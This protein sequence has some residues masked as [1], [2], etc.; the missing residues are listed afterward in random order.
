MS[1]TITYAI[2][3]PHVMLVNNSLYESQAPFW[4]Y[5]NNKLTCKFN[6]MEDAKLYI[7]VLLRYDIED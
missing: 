4:V 1:N 3:N 2:G 5:F 6:K 7:R